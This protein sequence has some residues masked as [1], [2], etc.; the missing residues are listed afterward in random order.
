M[1]A[2]AAPP[3]S[4]KTMAAALLAAPRSARL[5]RARVPVPA[6]DQVLVRV[7]GC[8]VCGSSL[9]VWEGRRW[10]EYPLPPGAP[11]H[12]GWG[13]IELLGRAVSGPEVGARVAFLSHNAFA[14]LDVAAADELV[15]L[16][17]ALDDVP[18]PG[19]ALGCAMNVLERSRIRAGDDVAVVGVGFLG[20]LLVQLAVRSG[21][22]V[23]AFARRAFAL[24]VAAALGAEETCVLEEAPHEPRF[25]RVI[26][27]G[28]AQATLDVA[29]RLVRE[30][31]L[32][33]IAGYHQDGPRAVDLQAWNWRG[34]DVVN[35]HERDPARYVHGMRRAVAAVASGLLDPRPLYTHRYRLDELG[36]A[37]GAVRERPDG[38]VKALVL[39]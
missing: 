20:L 30:R 12:E 3:V 36:S 23:V 25:D 38:F 2:A 17:P 27:A 21:A 24:E 34:L 11:G 8:G 26:E 28:G 6:P 10:F 1:P 16:P 31:G 29:S 15:E 33:V 32:L 9:P 7:E 22:R 4:R 39:P 18:F 37:L 5:E 19:E 14:E 13:R 35:A